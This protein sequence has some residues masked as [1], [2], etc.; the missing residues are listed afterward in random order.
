MSDF[1]KYV[2][3]Q[4]ARIT[5]M[6]TFFNNNFFEILV[7]AMIFP[8]FK[9][10]VWKLKNISSDSLSIHDGIMHLIIGIWIYKYV[11]IV[12]EIQTRIL[13]IML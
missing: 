12:S 3:M 5:F 1:G 9:W 6:Q 8:F 11:V 2:G 4:H 10:L 7:I 13:Q